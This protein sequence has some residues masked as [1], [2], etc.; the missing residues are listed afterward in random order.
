M[1][2][3]IRPL[4]TCFSRPYVVLQVRQRVQELVLPE[5]RVHQRVRQLLRLVVVLVLPRLLDRLLLRLELVLLQNL[6]LVVDAQLDQL[7]SQLDVPQVLHVLLV[8]EVVQ[9]LLVR[10]VVVQRTVV[11]FPLVFR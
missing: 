10:V 9:V 2:T 7:P 11:I 8:D 3:I 4:I 1:I 6:R 5:T